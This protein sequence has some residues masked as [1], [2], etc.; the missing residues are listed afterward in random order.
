MVQRV[1]TSI[2][3][4]VKYT[5]TVTPAKLRLIVINPMSEK[6]LLAQLQRGSF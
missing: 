2:Q 5:V 3:K 4:G 1:A 6:V